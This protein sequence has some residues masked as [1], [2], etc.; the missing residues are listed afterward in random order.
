MSDILERITAYKLEEVAA[1]KARRPPAA[2]EAAA[3]RSAAGARVRCRPGGQDGR[4]GLRPDRRDQEG[5][6]VEGPDPGRFRPGHPRRGLCRGRGRLSLGADRHPVVRRRAGA[7]HVARAASGLPALRKDFMLE[8]YQIAEARA[9][10][11]RLH[12]HHH[13]CGRRRHG[14]CAGGGGPALG[15]GRHR[16][17]PRRG[18]SSTARSGSTAASSASTTATSR[19]SSPRSTPPSGS[20]RTSRPAASSSPRAASPATPTSQRLA[21]VRRACLP[22]GREPDAPARRGCRDRSA[23]GRGGC[24]TATTSPQTPTVP[25]P[26]CGQGSEPAPTRSGSGRGD[27]AQAP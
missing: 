14:W 15:H 8:P 10:R 13:G 2:V 6:S 21:R 16:R 4:R 27:V 26:P 1:A 24:M 9:P 25:P 17:G 5:E 11:R 23:A 19:P 7:P 18:A 20:P 22:R 3:Q 12:P